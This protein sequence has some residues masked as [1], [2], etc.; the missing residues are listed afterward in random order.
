[1]SAFNGLEP[2]YDAV[3]VGARAAGAATAMLLAG[4]GLRVL[5]VDR[6]AY[7]S[8]TLSTHALMRLGVL[9]LARWGVLERIEAL[10]TP[11]VS[12]TVFHYPDEV[13][14]IPIKPQGAVP[15]LFAP[16]RTVLDRV[17]VDAAVEAGAMVRHRVR[18]ADLVRGAGGRVEGVVLQ[19]DDGASR[20][21]RSRV[22]IGADGLRSTVASLVEAPVTR[23]GA[24]AT[25]TIYGYWSG[26]DIEGYHWYWS[27]GLAAGAIPTNGNQV[28]LFAGMPARRFAEGAAAGLAPIYERVLD[29]CAPEIATR[30]GGARLV[31]SLRG[32]PGH[33]GFLRRPWGPGWAL[34]G[35]AGYFK[36]PITAH[37]L[38]DALRDAELLALAVSEGDDAALE[39]YELARDAVAGRFF[40]LT[41]RI[42]SLEWDTPE[43]KTL[44]RALSEE[45]K[46][47][48]REIN[49]IRDVRGEPATA[50]G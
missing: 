17:L 15:A 41:D 19:D 29:E 24:H 28:L 39:G 1:M 38:S 10:G 11:R 44:H 4:R 50:T 7:G 20:T 32:F 30:L 48:V 42:A 25:A 26:L 2:H 12:R 35:D 21:V 6:G 9:Q 8:D 14:D 16:R 18:L 13:V 37:G 3:V 36:D 45:M 33:P 40:E 31:G 27:R 22:V 47:E 46:R 49:R 43:L 34:V 5:A 23:P